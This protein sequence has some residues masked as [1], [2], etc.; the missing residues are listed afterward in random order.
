MIKQ[1]TNTMPNFFNYFALVLFFIVVNPYIARIHFYFEKNKYYAKKIMG[2]EKFHN[3]IIY[4]ADSLRHYWAVEHYIYITLFF[5]AFLSSSIL[6]TRNAYTH[7]LLLLYCFILLCFL[8]LLL[9]YLLLYHTLFLYFRIPTKNLTKTNY[10]LLYLLFLV[11][12]PPK[13][14]LSALFLHRSAFSPCLSLLPKTQ[15]LLMIFRLLLS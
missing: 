10:L 4:Y 5:F 2:A 8:L 9:L 1:K 3:Y 6:Y 12:Y 13:H 7:L 15:N 11:I 14:F